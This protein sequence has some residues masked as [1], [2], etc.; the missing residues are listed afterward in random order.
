M[1]VD[2]LYHS[3]DERGIGHLEDA[4]EV[5]IVFKH[6]DHGKNGPE[7]Y[8]FKKFVYIF[9]AGITNAT[10]CVQRKAKSPSKK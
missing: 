8:L 1:S 2:S 7:S 6:L 5:T 3:V 9:V 4:C 10:S